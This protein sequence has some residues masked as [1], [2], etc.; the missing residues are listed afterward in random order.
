MRT[1][2]QAN[3]FPLLETRSP[4]FLYNGT[5]QINFLVRF[6]TASELSETLKYV[7][8]FVITMKKMTHIY[9]KE[10]YNVNIKLTVL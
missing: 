10:L 1:N 7:T 2:L 3:H 4:L 8:N 5:A 9:M 6:R